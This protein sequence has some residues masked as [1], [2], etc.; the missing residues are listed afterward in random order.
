MSLFPGRAD[1]AVPK[2][3]SAARGRSAELQFA[4]PGPHLGVAQ[5]AVELVRMSDRL[6]RRRFPVRFEG[7]LA[8]AQRLAFEFDPIGI[9][10][11]AIQN[12]VGD[13]GIV[14]QFVP[15]ID[16]ELAGQKRGRLAMSVVEHFQQIAVL[17]AGGR[18]QPEVI[19]DQEP[20]WAVCSSRNNFG[21]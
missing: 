14:D 12:G 4:A 8:F 1:W 18:D 20:A 11:Q 15:L 19:N 2:W 3:G 17:F 5:S 10:H 13:G 7:G 21:A 6:I 9:M 16:R